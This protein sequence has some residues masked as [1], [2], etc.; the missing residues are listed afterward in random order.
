MLFICC[1]LYLLNSP[2]L[3]T[4]NWLLVPVIASTPQVN[5]VP[6]SISEQRLPMHCSCRF[7]PPVHIVYCHHL[8][9]PEPFKMPYL[10]TFL[11]ILTAV[12]VL[13][14]PEQDCTVS[15]ILVMFI[16]PR[17]ATNWKDTISKPTKKQRSNTMA[18][19]F[20]CPW[21]SRLTCSTS[22]CCQ[23]MKTATPWILAEH[24]VLP[25]C[26]HH[27]SFTIQNRQPRMFILIKSF[28]PVLGTRITTFDSVQVLAVCLL[29]YL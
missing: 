5:Q 15:L 17:H 28:T 13:R 16:H 2:I 12:R 10:S 25:R 19:F 1:V 3:S 24:L 6:C 18:I 29:L 20:Q 23:L 9:L 4:A 26:H 11:C 8:F 21:D 7:D 22:H 14:H 27:S